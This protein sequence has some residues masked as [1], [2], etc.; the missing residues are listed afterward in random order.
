MR[1]H[2]RLVLALALALIGLVG[3]PAL[4]CG[5]NWT[6]QLG[7]SEMESRRGVT[8]PRLIH[9]VDPEY[10]KASRKAKVQG[11]VVLSVL[12]TEN[13]EPQDL[14]VVRGLNP[15]LDEN[16]IRAV[17]RW[18]FAPATKNGNPVATK[19]NVEVTFRLY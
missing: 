13:G 7:E 5:E 1:R 19:V 18:R 11:I 8:P 4:L 9:S 17:S 10:D 16:A 15:A 3:T 14:K 2:L 6:G 12:V